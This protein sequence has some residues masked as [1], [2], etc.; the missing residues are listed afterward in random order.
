MDTFLAMTV[1]FILA[2]VVMMALF[3][4]GYLDKWF[5]GAIATADL[6]KLQATVS[7]LK[8]KAIELE[9]KIKAKL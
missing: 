2:T 8:V 3:F 1:G 5:G 7:E 6:A 9:A 4:L